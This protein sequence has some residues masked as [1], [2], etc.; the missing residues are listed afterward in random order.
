[1]LNRQFVVDGSE[2][3][4]GWKSSAKAS[5]QLGGCQARPPGR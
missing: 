3:A 5:V 4:A 2:P 1:M